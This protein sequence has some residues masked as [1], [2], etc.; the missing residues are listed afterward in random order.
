[1]SERDERRP[2]VR[3]V[4]RKDR[5]KTIETR[6]PLFPPEEEFAPE[7]EED[8]EKPPVLITPPE[9]RFPPVNP[10][11]PPQ[12][13]PTREHKRSALLP[14]LVAILFVIATLAAI[15]LFALIWTNPYTPLN[16]LAPP[17]P[18]PIIITA[19]PLPATATLPPTPGP[20]ASFTPLPPE[21]IGPTALPPATFTPA[22]FPFTLAESGVVYVPNANGEGCNWSSIAGSVTDLQGQPLNGYG[23]RVRGENRDET[24]FSGSAITFGPGGFELFLNGTPLA[25]EYTVQL[26]SPSGA[27]VSDEYPV[28]TRTS[29][30]QNV[31]I[32][33]FV[34]NRAL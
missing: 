17:T 13:L 22:L 24:V 34:Q 32:V 10:L 8:D 26:L 3:R 15:G 19:T 20:T 23:V 16:P 1:M 2:G 29:C 12:P 33:S 11:A 27:P 14:N 4:G 25:G 30:E 28:S 31:A 7:A 6:G 9:E 5:K 21:A 18:L